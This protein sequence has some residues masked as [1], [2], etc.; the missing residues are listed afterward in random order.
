MTVIP[1][2]LRSVEVEPLSFAIGA[3]VDLRIGALAAG[4]VRPRKGAEAFSYSNLARLL[5]GARM[6]WRE[7]G[8]HAGLA[9]ALPAELQSDLDPQLLSEAAQEAGCTRPNFGFEL[10]ERALVQAGPSLAEELRACGWGVILRGDPACPLPLGARARSLYTE[11][12]LDVTS[13]ADPFLALEGGDRTP[14]GQRVLAAR[15]SGILLTAESVR[16]AAEA[17]LL[18][19]AGFERGG[20]PFAEAGLR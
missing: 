3:R 16:N 17:R 12:V 10:N 11:L 7:R 13:A 4:V 19:I 9:L 18:A 15:E 14:F 1:F 5:R 8:A 20:G 2:P 6:A